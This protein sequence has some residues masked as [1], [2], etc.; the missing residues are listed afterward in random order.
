[1]R[2]D[3]WAGKLNV[4]IISVKNKFK[5]T[6]NEVANAFDFQTGSLS[7]WTGHWVPGSQ[8]GSM[9]FRLSCVIWFSLTRTGK[10]VERKWLWE[11]CFVRVGTGRVKARCW[12]WKCGGRQHAREYD[13]TFVPVL[14]GW[15]SGEEDQNCNRDWN[16]LHQS[17][18]FILFIRRFWLSAWLLTWR[19]FQNAIPCFSSLNSDDIGIIKECD[20]AVDMLTYIPKRTEL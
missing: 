8:W 12:H 19:S 14:G 2:S 6:A 16:S 9:M 11:A 3:A 13:T 10:L 18:A 1:M 4:L 15:E 5:N 17:S 7:A 20:K